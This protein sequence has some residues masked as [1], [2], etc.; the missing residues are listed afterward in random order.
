VIYCWAP[1]FVNHVVGIPWFE[2]D[3]NERKRVDKLKSVTDA[4]GVLMKVLMV[5][6][7]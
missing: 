4:N 3:V 6:R 7:F 1:D 2:V 5:M